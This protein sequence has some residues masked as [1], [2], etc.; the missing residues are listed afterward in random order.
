[1]NILLTSAGRRSYL[2]RYFREALGEE[3]VVHVGNSEPSIATQCGDAAVLTPLIY[4]PNYIP[5]LKDYCRKH[6]IGAILSLFD[7][8]LP[9]LAAHQTEFSELG[10]RVVLAPVETVALCND[11]WKA[12]CW[13]R[14][15]G[16]QT[17]RTFID[18]STAKRAIAAGELSYPVVVKPRWGM[19]SIGVNFAA[20]ERELDVFFQKSRDAAMESYLRFESTQTPDE[21]ILVQEKLTGQEH[22]LDVVN[23]LDGNYV[24]MFAKAKLSMRAGETDVGL[25]VDPSPFAE[26]GRRLSRLLQHHA[27]LSVD[28]FYDGRTVKIGELN[29]RISGHYPIAHLAGANLPKQIVRWLHGQGTDMDLLR[30]R[31]GI[32]VTKELVP[33]V[34][35]TVE[36]N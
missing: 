2:V 6:S 24:T 17:A 33:T 3:G 20:N 26:V 9:I 5:F 25:T 12:D 22:G 14:K 30:V 13:L 11:K 36:S 4:D 21:M 27:I 10:T 34:L 31:A 29:C 15:H 23:D 19:G 28:C 1:M 16:F 35:G 8:D 7:I 18:L 32:R